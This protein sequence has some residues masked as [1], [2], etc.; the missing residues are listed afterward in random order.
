MYGGVLYNCAAYDESTVI[1]SRGMVRS[2]RCYGSSTVHIGG[3]AGVTTGFDAYGESRIV[4]SD[5][6]IVVGD[7]YLY[8]RSMLEIRGGSVR[9]AVD[10]RGPST[11]QVSGGD[12]HEIYNEEA[13]RAWIVV[14]GGAVKELYATCGSVVLTGGKVERLEIEAI[15]SREPEVSI[16]G[17][18]VQAAP[19]GGELGYGLV[20]GYWNDGSLLQ[21]DLGWEA[22]GFL[23]IYDGVVPP[24]CRE[25]MGDLS[26]DCRVNFVDLSMLCSQWLA[27]EG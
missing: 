5:K 18:G 4:L 9:G 12:V 14:E 10:V 22:Y 17:N 26:G 16:V 15:R 7:H 24:M 23:H 19:Y 21:V 1:L 27:S 11:V 2:G 3:T 13:D 20:R 8:H 6:A 25:Q